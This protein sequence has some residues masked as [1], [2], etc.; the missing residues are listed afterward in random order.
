MVLVSSTIR[1]RVG[2]CS[3]STGRSVGGDA[4]RERE[5]ERD[6]SCKPRKHLVLEPGSLPSHYIR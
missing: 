6:Y 1:R 3:G 5:R 4:E 2:N